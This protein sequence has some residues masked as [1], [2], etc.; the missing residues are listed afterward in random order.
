[1]ELPHRV[2]RLKQLLLMG[3]KYHTYKIPQ[4]AFSCNCNAQI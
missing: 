4:E 2:F 1:M 3:D